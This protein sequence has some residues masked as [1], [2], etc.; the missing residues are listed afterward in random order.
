MRQIIGE[1]AQTP[2]ESWDGNRYMFIRTM[3]GNVKLIYLGK[4]KAGEW[5]SPSI[6]FELGKF[7]FSY[8]HP[9]Q[10]QHQKVSSGSNIRHHIYTYDVQLIVQ[11][12]IRQILLPSTSSRH[13]T[14]ST[15][16]IIERTSLNNSTGSRLWDCAISLACCMILQPILF[17]LDTSATSPE[18]HQ[19]V[20][21]G[22][23]CGLGSLAAAHIAGQSTPSRNHDIL[24]TDILATVD[25]TLSENLSRNQQV[26]IRTESLDWGILE[27]SRVLQLLNLTTSRIRPHLTII[28]S[29]ILYD[30]DT[31]SLLLETITSLLRPPATSKS[32]CLIAY[33]ARTE[34]D[35]NFF[36]LA[37]EGGLKVTRVWNWGELSVY[38]LLRV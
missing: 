25:T 34:G 15:T 35:D 33:K 2:I 3:S 21:L 7:T 32:R 20:E 5:F 9:L 1:T 16:S 24:A 11:T 31:H 26:R 4:H 30:P 38:E 14:S 29:D 37:Q 22:A 6:L 36:A 13:A 10:P 8:I 23:G 17:G 27:P 18:Q 12:S 19:L 28:G